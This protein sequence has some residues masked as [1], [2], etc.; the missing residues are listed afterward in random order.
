MDATKLS[1]FSHLDVNLG[2]LAETHRFET[3][4][5]FIELNESRRDKQAKLCGSHAGLRF[6]PVIVL[7]PSGVG[8]TTLSKQLT[9]LY[10]DHFGFSVSYTTRAPREGEVDGISYNFVKRTQFEKMAAQEDFIEQCIV[11]S[12]LYGTSKSQIMQ[13]QEEERI[14]LLDID[15]KGTQKFLRAFPEAHTIF[16]FPPSIEELEDRLI[17][18]GTETQNSLRIRM[19]EAKNEVNIALED[20]ADGSIIGYR[21]VNEDLEQCTDGFIKIMEALY[22]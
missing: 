3:V 20:I 4:K 19:S 12:N 6:R 2:M 15:I 22:H 1:C 14:P 7:G 10:P 11:H 5:R 9:R 16:I 18:R 13:I 21:L 8:K 17:A